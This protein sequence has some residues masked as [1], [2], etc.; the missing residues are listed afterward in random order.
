M[1]EKKTTGNCESRSYG[2][3]QPTEVLPHMQAALGMALRLTRM[4]PRTE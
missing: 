1:R 2:H 3:E 4:G